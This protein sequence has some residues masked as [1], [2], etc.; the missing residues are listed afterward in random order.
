LNKNNPNVCWQDGVL[1][2][3]LKTSK[4][5]LCPV[6]IQNPY[7]TN[8]VTSNINFLSS[9]IWNG[10]ASGFDGGNVTPPNHW[11]TTK[12]ASVWSPS[13]VL[14]WEPYAPTLADQ[15]QAFNDGAN[16]P[17]YGT[18]IQGLGT[19]HEKSGANVGR[20]DG[21]LT[22]MKVTDFISD[23]NTPSGQGP[24]PGGKTYTWW[25][26]YSSNGH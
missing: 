14:F 18:F 23:A 22:F 2:D 4:V 10:A 1:W 7:Y 13:C 11:V 8:R 24:G 25:S 6:D 12:I 20:L 16:F 19:L 26:V 15:Q 5:Y 3:Y 9:Y 17:A 21:S